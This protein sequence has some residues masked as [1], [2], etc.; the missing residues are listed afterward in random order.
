MPKLPKSLKGSNIRTETRFKKALTV[1]GTLSYHCMIPIT[2][3]K[4]KAK[5][6]S[7]QT[8]STDV[9]VMT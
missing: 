8:N 1:K 3:K 6:F 9:K 7:S 5:H 4:A 2:K